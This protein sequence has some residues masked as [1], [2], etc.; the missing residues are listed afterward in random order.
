[1]KIS[2]IVK[3]E[4]ENTQIVLHKEGLFYRVYERSAFLFVKYI[5]EYQVIKK[6]YKIVKQEV[7][8]LGFPQS[9]F[10]KIELV[11]K[12]Q[13]LQIKEDS[14]QIKITG[15]K[16]FTEREFINWKDEII[17]QEKKA[18]GLKENDI[19]KQISDFPL[20]SKTPIE[21]QQFLYNIQ[22]QINGD[23]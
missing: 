11:C 1:M 21:T 17:K 3:T 5:K 6:Y 20:A 15:L 18:S 14:K 16:S 23:L 13:S 9:S 22:K 2:E 10:S 4:Q 8:Y 19:L 7:A 12:E